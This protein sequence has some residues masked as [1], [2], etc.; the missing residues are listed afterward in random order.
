V[1][2]QNRILELVE[3]TA[4]SPAEAVDYHAVVD[5]GLTQAEWAK[6]RGISQQ[7][8]SKNLSAAR[9]KLEEVAN[10]G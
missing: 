9:P 5:L 1:P 3:S 2:G 10:G 4:L 6:R 7:A 8:V